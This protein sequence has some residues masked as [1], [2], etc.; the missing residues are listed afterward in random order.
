MN[1]ERLI[2]QEHAHW[3]TTQE[4]ALRAEKEEGG[5]EGH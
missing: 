2:S 3:E 1:V 5:K 4:D